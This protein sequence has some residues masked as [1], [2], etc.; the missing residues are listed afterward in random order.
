[1]P[2][3]NLMSRRLGWL[4]C[5]IL[6]GYRTLAIVT[7]ALLIV[8]LLTV[9]LDDPLFAT[10]TVTVLVPLNTT[11]VIVACSVCMKPVDK[12]PIHAAT[13]MLTATV[14]AIRIIDA[15]T[16]DRAFALC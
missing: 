7:T 12:P 5:L 2:S 13:A 11:F 4:L 8:A 14:T 1:M 10:V 15:T 16:G 9:M 6:V 3:L